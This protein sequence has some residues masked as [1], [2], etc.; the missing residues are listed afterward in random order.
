MNK[1]RIV[2]FRIL[3]T[4]LSLVLLL[5]IFAN[6]W[7]NGAQ[8]GIRSA[9]I[10]AW[11][12]RLLY[13]AW[14]DYRFTEHLVRKLAHFSE[15]LLLGFFLTT[16]LRVYTTRFFSHIAWVLF[17]GILIPVIDETIQLFSEGRGSSLRV[18]W[19]DVAGFSLGMTTA[20]LVIFLIRRRIKKGKK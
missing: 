15:Y 2:W 9:A 10:T 17:L 1:K 18:V 19:I 12:N 8:S 20:I 16:T 11:L 5:F 6:S 3:Y 14:I 4:L 13:H 7:Q